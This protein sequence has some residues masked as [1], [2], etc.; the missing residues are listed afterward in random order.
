MPKH[1]PSKFVVLPSARVLLLAAAVVGL[2][3]L[4]GCDD[5]GTDQAS[6]QAKTAVNTSARMTASAGDV[7]PSQK[8]IDAAA[9]PMD[10]AAMKKLAELATTKDGADSLIVVK[11]VQDD[12]AAA[13]KE[14]AAARA[15]TNTPAASKALVDAQ[16]GNTQVQQA[17]LSLAGMAADLQ[18]LDGV[19]N[20]LHAIS[21]DVATLAKE[22]AVLTDSRNAGLDKINADLAAAQSD[23]E[24][25]TQDAN[26]KDQMAK[27][28]ASHLDEQRQ[29]A[30]DLYSKAQQ[31][32]QAAALMH[33]QTSIDAFGAAVKLRAQADDISKD[34]ADQLPTLADQQTDAAIAAV[35]AREADTRV[36]SITARK[37]SATQY[38]AAIDKQIDSL[39]G[40]IKGLVDGD[41]GLAKQYAQYTKLRDQIEGKIKAVTDQTNAVRRPTPRPRRICD[42]IPP[43]FRTSSPGTRP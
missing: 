18:S 36:K 35:K 28:T 26:E 32:M 30:S 17:Q 10:D 6:K 5:S 7:R 33:G 23:A 1:S 42:L 2:C 40:E 31:G 20:G 27:S 16:F 15:N 37:D 25:A 43:R 38:Q 11:S 24:K 4:W 13:Q 8:L 34:I 21:T 39:N 9:T 22:V 41:N 12:L 29:Q 3:T 19:S 14:L